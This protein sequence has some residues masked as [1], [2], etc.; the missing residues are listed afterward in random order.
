MEL[1]LL[2]IIL[3]LLICLVIS[4]VIFIADYAEFKDKVQDI[5][6]LDTKIN[7]TSRE[8]FLHVKDVIND[9]NRV[10]TFISRIIGFNDKIVRHFVVKS[11]EENKD[12]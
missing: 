10:M 12:E 8:I 1:K 9:N 2:S 3:G 11:D 7:N 6:D 4:F 5:V